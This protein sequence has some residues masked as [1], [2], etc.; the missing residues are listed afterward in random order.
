MALGIKEV[1]QLEGQ[2]ILLPRSGTIAH[3]LKVINR[4]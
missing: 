1:N 3:D 2:D 4:H